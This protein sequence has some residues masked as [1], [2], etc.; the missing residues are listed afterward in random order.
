MKESDECRASSNLFRVAQNLSGRIRNY[1]VS[2]LSFS[3]HN[4][5]Y[6][7]SMYSVSFTS[8]YLQNGC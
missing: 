8:R 5:H 4:I 3:L 1:S 7:N 2:R 6:V